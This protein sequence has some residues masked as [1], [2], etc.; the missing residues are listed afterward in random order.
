MTKEERKLHLKETLEQG[1]KAQDGDD[2]VFGVGLYLKLPEDLEPL[3]DEYTRDS[4]P[5]FDP[6]LG[7]NKG[8][9][10]QE[11]FEDFAQDEMKCHLENQFFRKLGRHKEQEDRK[12][13]R[14]LVYWAGSRWVKLSLTKRLATRS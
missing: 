5:K 14:D 10:A 12:A 1:R 7:G 9:M 8:G 13:T 6:G 3:Y 4:F 2:K 11:G